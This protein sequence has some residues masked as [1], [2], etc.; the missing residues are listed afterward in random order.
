MADQTAPNNKIKFAY[1]LPGWS[2]DDGDK[3]ELKRNGR[4]VPTG[5][6]EPHM[7]D[8]L[9]CPACCA[10]LYRSPKKTITFTNGRVAR[11]AHK[12]SVKVPCDLRSKQAEGK[13]YVNEEEARAA[14]E[15]GDLVVVS[16]FL[17]EQPIIDGIENGPYDETPVEDR[18]GPVTEVPIARHNG[19]TYALPSRI[20]SV[21]SLCRDFD[22]NLYRYY[23]LP[24]AQ[25]AVRLIDALKNV[26]ELTGP[27][28]M[29]GLYYG[30]IE[31]TSVAVY[32]VART[33]NIRM[34]RLKFE[35]AGKEYVDFTL[36]DPDS[37]QREKGITDASKGRV[38]LFWGRIVESGIGLAVERP[39]WGEYA[40][41]P[42]MYTVLLDL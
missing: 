36:K 20:T 23:V 40:L 10:P 39:G 34:T 35:K 17:K 37:A 11:Y 25:H 21:R 38:V 7:D 15:S 22:V 18:S 33:S 5:E 8:S 1:F 30:V 41:L 42:E 3:A 6:Y 31:E 24:G 19:E 9:F 32:R 13:V 12:P 4:K 2:F 29:P 27:T 16:G 26:R 28:S 14:I